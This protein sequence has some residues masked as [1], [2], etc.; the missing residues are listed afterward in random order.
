MDLFTPLNGDKFIEHK[1][2][3][4]GHTAPK[5]ERT[6]NENM[7]IKTVGLDHF[8]LGLDEEGNEVKIKV[9]ETGELYQEVDDKAEETVADED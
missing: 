2:Y 7:D 8:I 3:K 9:D 1:V 4:L 5:K 6:M